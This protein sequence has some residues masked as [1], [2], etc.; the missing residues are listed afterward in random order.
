[1]KSDKN[2]RPPMSAIGMGYAAL[3]VFCWAAYNV[4]AKAGM[5]GA[6]RAQDL[7]TLRFGVAGLLLM[8]LAV[9]RFR[10]F[11]NS[12]G[13]WRILVLAGLSGPV[14]GIVV[15]GGF[16]YAPL[17]H[18]M[19][20]APSAAMTVGTAL[21][22][23]FDGHSVSRQRIAGMLTMLAGLFLLVGFEFDSTGPKLLLGEAMFLAGG[24]M[25]GTFS[26]LLGRWKLDAL[27]TT[28]VVGTMSGALAI[29]IYLMTWG[30]SLP[31]VTPSEIALQAFMQ[32]IL[33]GGVAVYAM[34][35]STEHLG[36]AQ[37]ALLPIFTPAV[38]MVIS[39]I[40]IGTVPSLG[41]I[42]G[43]LIVTLG[44]AIALKG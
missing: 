40:F 17:S 11:W 41:E 38:G 25:W 2:S 3:L 37:V 23:L 30:G 24:S 42:A 43:A 44:L 31:P 22:V 8:P 34:V 35:K 20:F 28:C 14:F 32:G 7:S 21:S 5:D 33:G 29:P 4:A 27:A 39:A 36:A 15:V 18:G 16:A 13:I 12:I 10:R 1:M 19:L 9:T 6:F 26:F